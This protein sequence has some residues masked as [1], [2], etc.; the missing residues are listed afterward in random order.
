MAT[1]H[2]EAKEPEEGLVVQ[3]GV[4]ASNP[5]DAK[6]KNGGKKA[7]K[8]EKDLLSLAKLF[9]FADSTDIA[10]MTV[11]STCA[12]ITG[13]A[14]PYFVLIFGQTVD[15]INDNSAGSD[16]V[17]RYVITFAVSGVVALFGGGMMVACW[18][19]AG[20]RQALR[21]KGA[22]VRAILRQDIGWFDDHPPGQLPTLVTASMAKI[23]DGIGRKVSDIVMNTASFFGCFIVSFYINAHLAAVMLA[24]IPF[25]G[26]SVALVAKF[27][28]K[29][30]KEGDAYYA[31]AGAVANEVFG[32]IRTVASLCSESF[33]ASEDN[34]FLSLSWSSVNRYSGHLGGAEKAG[35]KSGTQK[36]LGSGALFSAFFLSYALAFWYGTKQVADDLESECASDC[37]TGGDVIATIFGILIG[38]MALGQM[39]PGLTALGLARSSAVTVFETIDRVPAIDSASDGGNTLSK[40]SGELE[41]REVGFSYPARPDDMVYESLSLSIACGETIALVGPSGGGKSTMTK[42]LLRLYDPTA[43]AVLL[44]GCDVRGLN[45]RWYR[46]QI[47]YVGQE[48][49]LFSGTI[50]DNI[51]NGKPGCSEEDIVAAA[52]AANAHRFIQAFPDGYATSVGEGGLQLSGGQKQRIA[53]ARAVIKDPAILLLDE[54]TSALD[55]ESEKVVQAAL[56][57]LHRQ[58]RRTTVTI[59]HRLSTIQN[60]DR[61]A[62][63]ANHGIAEIGTH[64]ELLAMRGIYATL[65]ATQVSDSDAVEETPQ[66][67]EADVARDLEEEVRQI[68]EASH[69][70]SGADAVGAASIPAAGML[71]P[72]AGGGSSGAPP[73]V[74]QRSASRSG[75]GGGSSSNGGVK[76]HRAESV[77]GAVPLT[78]KQ[79]EAAEAAAAKA[80][81][82]PP[83][84]G[85]RMW[86]LS[87]PEYPYFMIGMFGAVMAGA[88]FPVEGVLIANLQANLYLTDPAEVRRQGNKWASGFVVLAAAGLI[89]HLCLSYGFAVMGERLT[90]RLREMCFGAFVRKDIGWFD[91][92]EHGTGVLTTRLESDAAKVQNATGVTL[93][94]QMM[95]AMTLLLGAAIGLYSSW[96]IG[97]VAM[98]LIPVMA[99]AGVMQ[100]SCGVTSAFFDGL[101]GG[102]GAGVILGGALNGVTTV[103]AFNMQAKVGKD[104]TAAI[105]H[106]IAARQRRGVLAG[107]AFGYSQGAMFWVFA[108]LFWYGSRL[109]QVR[110]GKVLCGAAWRDRVF[111]YYKR[112]V[113]SFNP[114]AFGVGQINAEMGA[115]KEGQQAAARIFKAVDEGFKIDPLSE[116]GAKPAAVS[117]AVSFHGVKFAYPN[118]PHVQIY[119]SEE[120][121]EGFNLDVKAGQTV[122]LVGPSGC[123]KS[124]CIQLLM[125]FYDPAAG[126]VLFDGRDVR[127]LNVRWLRTQIGYVGQEPVLFTGTIRDNIKLGKLDATEEEVVAAAKAANAHDFILAFTDG[128]STD[129]GEKSALLSGGQ[130]QRIAIARAIIKDPTVLLLDEATSALDNESERQVQEALDHLQALKKRTTLIVAHRLKT[131]RNA[132]AIAVISGGGVTELGTHDE[133]LKKKDGTYAMLYNMQTQKFSQ[134][135]KAQKERD[136]EAAAAIA[137]AA[138]AANGTA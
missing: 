31:K 8:K 28:S 69:I 125:R 34:I 36:G 6:P 33:Q 124:T 2:G 37:I 62:V 116:E 90:R 99:F 95:L 131:V 55:S 15:Q 35:I 65:C 11:G 115:Q 136:C 27:M 59:A 30:S 80:A 76:M 74:R 70:N 100:V 138:V 20:E 130:K 24:C 73:E 134:S 88:L 26:G 93:S 56:D 43:G 32:G 29:S 66:E 132:D 78:R 52:K 86:A 75:V 97:L 22:Y 113:G 21:I 58:K 105:A 64:E 89:G 79:I 47:G 120:R 46:Q 98:A 10:F 3:K 49:T 91:Y 61:I 18:A 107:L 137:A 122:A 44:D 45:V 87:K 96:R 106:T 133:L 101:D 72:A 119:G 54:A 92:E 94:Q 38:A 14:M 51:A 128:Y 102:V 16:T 83:P 112:W 23:Q 114:L 77:S 104:Y 129:V 81:E 123:G 103:T 84:A 50:R 60:S 41:L 17:N 1:V 4:I 53:I 121:P 39:N 82:L 63:V 19:F 118:R 117:G 9:S 108:L 110:A 42:L 25:I 12:C 13:L 111:K 5:I 135:L 85:S 71:S 126:A 109:V 68:R 67:L 7:T 127:E 48:P 40:V 57:D